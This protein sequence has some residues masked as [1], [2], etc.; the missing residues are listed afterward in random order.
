MTPLEKVADKAIRAA[1]AYIP[2][3]SHHRRC[4]NANCRRCAYE[5][6]LAEYLAIARPA[7]ANHCDGCG[8][9]SNGGTHLRSCSFRDEAAAPIDR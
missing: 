8:D 4:D 7:D 9:L 1:I 3:N 5:T 6:A 2:P